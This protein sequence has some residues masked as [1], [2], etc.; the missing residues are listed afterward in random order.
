MAFDRVLELQDR[1]EI[2]QARKTLAKTLD[3]IEFEL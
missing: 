3:E 2:E 1:L